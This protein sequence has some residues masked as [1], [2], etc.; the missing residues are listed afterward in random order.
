M[1]LVPDAQRAPAIAMPQVRRQPARLVVFETPGDKVV[2]HEDAGRDKGK[3]VYGA[4]RV[5]LE[6]AQQV[7]NHQHRKDCPRHMHH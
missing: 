2:E 7:K 3:N 6:Y 5:E 1:R 4:G